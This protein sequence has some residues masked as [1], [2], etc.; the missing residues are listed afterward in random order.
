MLGVTIPA[1][2]GEGDGE[3]IHQPAYWKATAVMVAV[4]VAC[5]VYLRSAC[6]RWRWWSNGINNDCLSCFPR[7]CP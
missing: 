5:A 4:C 6:G 3:T 1:G 2:G 7:R